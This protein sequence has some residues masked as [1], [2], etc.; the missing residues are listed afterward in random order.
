MSE[1]L[2]VVDGA[3]EPDTDA[4][5]SPNSHRTED[6][7]QRHQR[8]R[9]T[10]KST[11]D[12]DGKALKDLAVAN[13]MA[14]LRKPTTKS[15]GDCIIE[16]IE[17]GEGNDAAY[18]VCLANSAVITATIKQLLDPRHMDGAITQAVKRA[19]D[20]YT[21]KEW[22]PFAVAVIQAAKPDNATG[23][24]DAETRE[25]LASF[26]RPNRVWQ[27]DLTDSDALFDALAQ[28][29]TF[30]GSDDR[31][32]IRPPSLLT[33]VVTIL[34]QR[35]S[36]PDLRRRLGRLGFSN[37]KNAEGKLTARRGKATETQ[38]YLASPPGW[39]VD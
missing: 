14:G 16:V 38:R 25:W 37:P 2:R 11:T 34:K 33:H 4:A 32:Y 29:R 20:W 17:R 1:R 10:P 36:S 24:A 13:K 3:T 12:R 15:P 23:G 27:V 5:P 19:P 35:T 18:D 22:R 39:E 8:A 30:R 21:P 6:A 26:V 28:Q 9:A 7:F 31:L